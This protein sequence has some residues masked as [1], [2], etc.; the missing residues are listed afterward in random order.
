MDNLQVIT[1]DILNNKVFDYIYTKQYDVGRQVKFNIVE[2]GKP[3]NIDSCDC[4]FSLMK[5]DGY[6][7]IDKLKLYNS[8]VTITL[9]EQCTAVAGRLPYQ[10]S[11]TV[12]DK[13][14]STVTGTIIC[15][16]ATVQSDDVKS[17]SGGNLIEDLIELYENNLF[18]PKLITLLANG[19]DENNQQ[20]IEVD[21][22]SGN[23]GNQLVA[24]HPRSTNVRE[25][26]Q[27]QIMCVEQGEGYLVFEC[28]SVPSQDLEVYVLTQ[29]INSRLGN[30]S[31]TYS[32]TEP[33]STD[34]NV[35]DVWLQDY[36]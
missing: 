30:V 19:W 8:S 5:P 27:S 14:I 33:R 32:D 23:E 28:L 10:L 16:K 9:D 4:V 36:E 13:I 7:I 22:V 21:V 1:L 25:Y 20:R 17:S 15:D 24:I 6:V 34:Q 12:D 2:D 3:I 11:L 26:A 18:Q 31:I 29:G 35:N